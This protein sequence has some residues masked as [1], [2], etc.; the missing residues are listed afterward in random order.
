[1]FTSRAGLIKK[2]KVPPVHQVMK[3]LPLQGRQIISVGGK[4]HKVKSKT[5]LVKER[6]RH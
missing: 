4:K 1:M 6:R 2:K 5:K 3:D